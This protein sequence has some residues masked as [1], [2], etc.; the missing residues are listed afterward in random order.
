M[1]KLYVLILLKKKTLWIYINLFFQLLVTMNWLFLFLCFNNKKNILVIIIVYLQFIL[2][3][4]WINIFKL[5][6][7]EYFLL[8]LPPL[9]SNL[10]SATVRTPFIM[11]DASSFI[12]FFFPFSLLYLHSGL[13]LIEIVLILRYLLFYINFYGLKYGYSHVNCT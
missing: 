8:I 3:L 11:Q 5:F 9:N 7:F 13:I 1:S 6:F 2:L 12:G 10:G 4:L